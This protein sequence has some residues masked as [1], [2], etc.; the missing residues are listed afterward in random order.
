MGRFGLLVVALLAV[1]CGALGWAVIATPELAA[2]PS[3]TESPAIDDRPSG[4]PPSAAGSSPSSAESR[5]VRPSP[6]DAPSPAPA[7]PT[8]PVVDAAMQ[9]PAPPV[10]APTRVSVGSL[11]VD[12][13]VVA[14][15]LDGAGAMALPPDP[16]IA[17]WYEHGPA[18]ASTAGA[19]VIA[20]HVDSL[21]YGLGPF[22]ALADATAGTEIVVTDAAGTARTFAVSTI[23]TTGKSDVAWASVFDRTGP[24]RLVLVTCGGEFDYSS[25][26]YLSNVIIVATPVG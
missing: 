16:A 18:P 5:S 10:P 13:P 3:S 26:H 9:S 14:V 21:V 8:V 1:F 19:T 22:A 17:G 24:A 20:A 2:S 11:G 15:G 7:L 4:S 6:T 12:V 25:R 23:E